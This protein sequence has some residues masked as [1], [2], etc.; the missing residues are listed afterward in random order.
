MDL[1][2]IDVGVKCVILEMYILEM[3]ILRDGKMVF[4]V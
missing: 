4:F 2:K 3:C 1:I